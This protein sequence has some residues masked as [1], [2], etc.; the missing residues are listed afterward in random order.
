MLRRPG[1]WRW[2]AGIAAILVAVPVA[3]LVL[4]PWGAHD[5]FA[6]PLMLESVDVDR[7]CPEVHRY[8]GDSSHARDWSVYVD[9]ITPLNAD[10][11]P[12]GAAGSIRRS[13]RNADESGTRW[14]EYFEVVEPRRRRLTIYGIHGA[15]RPAGELMTEQLYEPLGPDACRLTFTLFLRDEPSLGDRLL[16]G[17]ASWE[18][19]RIFRANLGN[20]KQRVEAG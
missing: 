4:S 15:P 10:E 9:H 16:L 17:L 8:L 20:I 14:D 19:A 11:V 7:S 12:D 2:A 5:G 6:Y 13:F 1:R 3:A 18:V